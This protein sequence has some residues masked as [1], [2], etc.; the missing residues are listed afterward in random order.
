MGAQPLSELHQM[1]HDAKVALGEE[2][3]PL[4]EHKLATPEQRAQAQK[5]VAAAIARKRAEN[6]RTE[7][8]LRGDTETLE[9]W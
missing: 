7:A 2:M 1:I 8:Y 4:D 6:E 3:P 5:E 9:A